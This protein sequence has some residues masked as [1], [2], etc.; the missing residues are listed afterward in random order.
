MARHESF[1]RSALERGLVA[2]AELSRQSCPRQRHGAGTWTIGQPA[3]G[4]C[5]AQRPGD[6]RRAARAC[7][8]R[9]DGA[10]TGAARTVLS[11]A[12]GAGRTVIVMVRIWLFRVR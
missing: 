11:A 5:R 3:A 10:G 1:L 7:Q 12:A 2:S 4:D 9:A 6:A 8:H